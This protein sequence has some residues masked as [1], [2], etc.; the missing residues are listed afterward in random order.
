MTLVKWSMVVYG[1]ALIAMGVQAAFFPH[2]GG[3]ASPVSLAAAGGMGMV[4]LM[5]TWLSFKAPRPAYIVT[6]VI[7]ALAILRFLPKLLSEQ[8]LYPAGLTVLLSVAVAA[9]LGSGHMMAM[10]AKKASES[11]SV[12]A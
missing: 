10:K 8:Q 6:L 5:M 2:E 12:E 7:A 9:V 11:D 4:V 1:I 3:K